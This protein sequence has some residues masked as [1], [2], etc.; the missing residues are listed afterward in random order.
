MPLSRDSLQERQTKA[1]LRAQF[2]LKQTLERL[3]WEE[4]ELFPQIEKMKAG[5]SVFG[6]P[7]GVAFEMVVD[8]ANSHPAKAVAGATKRRRR[9]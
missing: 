1:V 7:D 3:A 6:L 9:R 2:R 4:S 5:K 8:D